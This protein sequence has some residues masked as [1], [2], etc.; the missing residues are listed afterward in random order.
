MCCTEKK[1]QS[2]SHHSSFGKSHCCNS[3]TQLWSK[4]RKIQKLNEHLTCLKEKQR[5][6][7]ELISELEE[8]K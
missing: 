4:K 5:D 6:I 2:A 8:E 3:G 7:E 1:H